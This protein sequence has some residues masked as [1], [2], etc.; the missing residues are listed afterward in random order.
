MIRVAV[1]GYGNI[2]KSAVE[3]LFQAPDMELAGVVRERN[4]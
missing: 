2:G 4:H 1:I 3:A